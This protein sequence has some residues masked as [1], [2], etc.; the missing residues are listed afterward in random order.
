MLS[1]LIGN[2][3]YGGSVTIIVTGGTPRTFAIEG[4]DFS[5]TAYYSSYKENL[6]RQRTDE[7]IEILRD[8]DTIRATTEGNDL[9]AAL[10][11]AQ[12]ALNEA[13]DRSRNGLKER[14][15]IIFDT[16]IVT[17]GHM[18][19]LRLGISEI[20]FVTNT[21]EKLSEINS[22]ISNE[23][24]RRHLLPDLQG[25]K[26]T[27]AGL[28]D[29]C[30]V[31]QTIPNSALIGV[32]ELWRT[33]L[34][35]AGVDESDIDFKSYTFGTNPNLHTPE[36][37]VC[38]DDCHGCDWFPFVPTIDFN[39][40]EFDLSHQLQ[41]MFA[42]LTTAN[43]YGDT[44]S[45]QENRGNGNMPPPPPLS[46]HNDALGFLPNSYI[47][48]DPANFEFILAEYAKQLI[49]YLEHHRSITLYI[50]GTMARANRTPNP[51][52]ILSTKRAEV[53]MDVLVR[54]GVPENRLR[55][56]GLGESGDPWRKDEWATGSFNEAVARLNRKTMLIPSNSEQALRLPWE[57]I[58]P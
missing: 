50:A 22:T 19:F 31:H 9:L 20:D 7:I 55:A 14:H 8:T 39:S 29:T 57:M 28:G 18:D 3:T 56:F 44:T 54:H 33:V 34:I 30:N 42:A 2:A 24:L 16:G 32:R 23:L 21:D 40:D 1:D 51:C 15:I 52:L 58:Q 48:R 38:D 12:A 46:I 5:A 53:V 10:V 41:A 43:V 4:I 26:I 27:W 47:V 35:S 49:P 17:D 36:G 45:E 11:Q 37:H 6:I 25:V 13:E